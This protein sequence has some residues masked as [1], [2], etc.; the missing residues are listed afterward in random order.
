V[1]ILNG[2]SLSLVRQW[3]VMRFSVVAIVWFA[4]VVGRAV[5]SGYISESQ[6]AART[7]RDGVYSEAQA[8]RGKTVYV[9]QCAGCHLDSLGGADMA[10]GLV[11]ETFE[12]E[13]ADLTVGDLFE[14]IRLSMPQ[15]SPA[16]LPRQ[17]YVDVVTY[18]LQANKFPAGP[19]ELG[20]D[21]P[22]LKAIKIVKHTE[23]H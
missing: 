5:T 18:L 12:A 10:P 16:S 1:E 22:T 2:E 21:L 9:E 14:R 20:D 17:A 4:A 3:A 11:G 23:R 8:A 6:T 19:T 13:W 15:D 7:V